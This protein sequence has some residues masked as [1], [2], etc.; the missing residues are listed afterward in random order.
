MQEQDHYL[1]VKNDYYTLKVH[2]IN[3]N[4]VTNHAFSVLYYG[5]CRESGMNP[6]NQ[7]V[8]KSKP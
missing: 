1:N 5:V 2:D 8:K 7:N 3:S 4:K 6:N